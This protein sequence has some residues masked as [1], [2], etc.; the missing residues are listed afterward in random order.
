[1]SKDN[2]PVAFALQVGNE[3]GR[4][5]FPGAHQQVDRAGTPTMGR[6]CEPTLR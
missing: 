6:Q 4:F 2:E 5:K 3:L 1:M